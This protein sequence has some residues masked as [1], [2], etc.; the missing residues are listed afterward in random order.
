MKTQPRRSAPQLR[1][2]RAR[3]GGQALTRLPVCIDPSHSVGRRALAPDGLLDIF[4]VTA[5]AVIAGANMVLV[6]LHPEPAEALC[7]GPQALLLDELPFFLQDI[8]IAR[9]AYE[10]RRA[11]ARRRWPSRR[12]ATLSFDDG[13][14]ALHADGVARRWA[15]HRAGVGAVVDPER[16][17]RRHHRHRRR[18]VRARRPASRAGGWRSSAVSSVAARS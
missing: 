12:R 2:L 11:L 14:R 1:R 5:Q 15:A 4:H 17:R 9:R 8:A 7:D 10:E 18:A 13:P 16:A 6:D 3:A